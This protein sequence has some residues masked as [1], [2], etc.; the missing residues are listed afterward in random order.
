MKGLIFLLLLIF[1]F[2]AFSYGQEQADSVLSLSLDDSIAIA[3]KNNREIQIQEQEIQAAKG[4]ILEAKS[5][6]LPKLNLDSAYT[7]N[8]AVLDKNSGS[9]KKDIRIFSGF[10]DE[11]KLGVSFNEAI[12]TGGANISKLAMAKLGL[13]TQGETLR[14]K[15]LDIEFEAKRLFYGLLLAYETERIMKELV[16]EAEAHYQNVKRKFEHGTSSKF[17]L[18]QSKVHVSLA[19]PELVKSS[20][21]VDLIKAELKKLLYLKMQDA[22]GLKGKLE[23]LPVEIREGEFLKEAYLNMPEMILKSLGIDIK[24][25]AVKVARSSGLPQIA[26]GGGYDY[27][28]NDW[29]NMFNKRHN[30]WNIGVTFTMPIFDGFYTKA[31]VEQAKARYAQANLAKEDLVEQVAV[32]IRKACL[33]LVKAQSIIDS[34]RDNIEEAREALFISEIS[35]D[36]GV[37]TNL[38]VLDAQVALSQVEKNLSEGIYDYI[39]AKAALDRVMGRQYLKE[40]G[41]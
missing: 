17:D 27:L 20:A 3:F 7:H 40:A 21:A 26:A 32:D 33:D 37:G 34:Q 31:K 30:N 9:G 15:K 39:M 14:A 10:I 11:N 24:K 5:A 16:D 29:G 13:N 4:Q 38:D 41:D 28:S 22:I 1:I 23:Y 2:P 6:L 19:V 35:Y 8:G 12:F 18:L 25:W 36:N